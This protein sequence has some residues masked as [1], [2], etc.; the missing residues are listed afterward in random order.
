[1][2]IL[3][4][5]CLVH[6]VAPE[7]GA[8]AGKSHSWLQANDRPYLERIASGASAFNW[9]SEAGASLTLG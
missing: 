9:S 2:D 8:H 6:S 4:R 7:R 1:M 5:D 3:D